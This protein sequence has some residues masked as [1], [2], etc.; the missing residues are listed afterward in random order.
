L[1]E[2]REKNRTKRTFIRLLREPFGN[3][4]GKRTGQLIIE[5]ATLQLT[6]DA[7]C[8]ISAKGSRT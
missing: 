8:G 5:A 2:K 3:S 4:G 1:E 6:N 7:F